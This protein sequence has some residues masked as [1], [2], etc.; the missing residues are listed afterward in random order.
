M[1]KNFR[2]YQLALDFYRQARCQKLSS[3]LSSQLTRA[4]SSVALNLAEGHGRQT[5]AD[6]RRF[7]TIAFGSLRECQSILDLASSPTPQSVE[8]ADILGAHIYKLI[9]ACY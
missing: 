9:K 8:C 6:Q 3:D 1:L 7:F 5:K 4:A 2:A